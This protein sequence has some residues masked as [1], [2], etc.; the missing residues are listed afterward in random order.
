MPAGTTPSPVQSGHVMLN[1]ARIARRMNSLLFGSLSRNS[2]KSSST[3]KATICDFSALSFLSFAMTRPAGILGLTSSYFFHPA[4][5]M[6]LAALARAL[7]PLPCRKLRLHDLVVLH[8][9]V[10]F[11]PTLS[12]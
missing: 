7:L 2:A 10:E 4:P 11:E 8:G 1:C 9:H 5:A 12:L 6:R 3:L